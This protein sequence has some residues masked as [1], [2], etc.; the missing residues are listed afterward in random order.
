MDKVDSCILHTLVSA[1]GTVHHIDRKIF[2]I[3][4]FIESLYTKTPRLQWRPGFKS[5]FISSTCSLPVVLGWAR[6]R[7]LD[8]RR[9]LRIA[10]FDTHKAVSAYLFFQCSDRKEL[11]NPDS[12]RFAACQP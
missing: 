7:A 9:D 2:N 5:P 8:G 11:G 4:S 12:I 1:T 10:I 6:K 3:Q